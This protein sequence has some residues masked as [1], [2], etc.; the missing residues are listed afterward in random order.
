MQNHLH[1]SLFRHP[2]TEPMTG[3]TSILLIAVSQFQGALQAISSD[4]QGR[5]IA[6]FHHDLDWRV[7]VERR[8]AIGMSTEQLQQL[9]TATEHVA[10]T[11]KATLPYIN[12][13]QRFV[14]DIFNNTIV[15]ILIH[16]IFDNCTLSSDP[17]VTQMVKHWEARVI[18]PLMDHIHQTPALIPLLGNEPLI[19]D[20]A[21]MERW[22]R[23]EGD[24]KRGMFQTI[25][26]MIV[27]GLYKALKK[28]LSS[29]HVPSSALGNLVCA[30]LHAT[31]PETRA[32][33]A[34]LLP[35]LLSN[36]DYRPSIGV[37]TTIA[38]M[39]PGRIT[40]VPIDIVIDNQI[41]MPEYRDMNV[42]ND[43]DWQDDLLQV[44][45]HIICVKEPLT[46]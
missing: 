23:Y 9:M 30:G 15:D 12:L 36:P 44:A 7:V 18:M 26:S 32:D 42:P 45:K 4:I 34:A 39:T 16:S 5:R 28:P 41:G 38:A 35:I 3:P 13:N 21:V 6:T 8:N 2:V 40:R 29:P 37:C 33:I 17:R 14:S 24:P 46:T 31:D 10:T 27:K 1:I 11:L 19:G 20:A 22:A 25:G 43:L